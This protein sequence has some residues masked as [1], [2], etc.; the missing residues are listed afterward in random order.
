MG[1]APANAETRMESE[2]GRLF[3]RF[4]RYLRRLIFLLYKH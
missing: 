1:D 2:R 4:S 3:V